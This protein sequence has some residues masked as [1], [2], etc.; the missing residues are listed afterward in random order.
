MSAVAF[1]ET[2]ETG[3]E[4]R[5]G[6]GTLFRGAGAWLT[7]HRG[8][9]IKVALL[10]AAIT[11]LMLTGGALAAVHSAGVAAVMSNAP[12]AL[13]LGMFGTLILG[14][15]LM[16]VRQGRENHL[17]TA[18]SAPLR[19]FHAEPA[20]TIKATPDPQIQPIVEQ[21]PQRSLA[22]RNGWTWMMGPAER[23]T[24][25]NDARVADMVR[26]LKVRYYEEQ[27]LPRAAAAGTMD[28]S[29]FGSLHEDVLAAPPASGNLVVAPV[30]L[31]NDAGKP[32]KGMALLEARAQ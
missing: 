2:R 24:Y 32:L 28:S 18:G 14:S 12:A 1:D 13:M 17:A 23:A 8:T 19:R 22:W 15:G 27:I 30:A 20:V 29:A 6:W 7:A 5:T 4:P 26:E 9:I 21:E 3:S 16:A 31:T 10:A 11:L 25:N